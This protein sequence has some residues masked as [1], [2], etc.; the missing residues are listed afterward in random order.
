MTLL[1]LGE[2]KASICF[3]EPLIALGLGLHEDKSNPISG[4]LEEF[5]VLSRI[6]RCLFLLFLFAAHRQGLYRY[7]N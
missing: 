5:R 3:R 4:R 1:K 7:L 6:K 2:C